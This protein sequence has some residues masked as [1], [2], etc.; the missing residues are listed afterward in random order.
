[1]WQLY[2]HIL[3][4]PIWPPLNNDSL[5]MAL[6]EARILATRKHKEYAKKITL[7]VCV[8][9]KVTPTLRQHQ[10]MRFSKGTPQTWPKKPQE[11]LPYLAKEAPRDAPEIGQRRPK[12]RLSNLV[13]EAPKKAPQLGWKKHKQIIS[14]LDRNGS[15]EVDSNSI[16]EF[17]KCE[18]PIIERARKFGPTPSK[19]FRKCSASAPS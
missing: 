5:A 3:V 13:G 16:Y 17:K 8:L 19:E 12:R 2:C 11:M 15:I 14:Q 10:L 7:G 9:T 18:P 1:M 4:F 6:E